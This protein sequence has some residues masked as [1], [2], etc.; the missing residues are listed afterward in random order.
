MMTPPHRRSENRN[1]KCKGEERQGTERKKQSH[2]PTTPHPHLLEVGREEGEV[3]LGEPRALVDEAG[4]KN[5]QRQVVL[6]LLGV[7][8]VGG[9][10]E[11]DAVPV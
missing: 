9:Q 8:G 3:V 5:I 10:G 2:H 7:G 4:V 1:P 6:L 11:G